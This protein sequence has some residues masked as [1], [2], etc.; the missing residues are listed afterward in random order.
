[1]KT[2]VQILTNH[3]LYYPIQHLS[4]YALKVFQSLK[5]NY[6]ASIPL[7]KVFSKKVGDTLIVYF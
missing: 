6:F 1:M 7:H 5:L 4:I 2:V 3:Y